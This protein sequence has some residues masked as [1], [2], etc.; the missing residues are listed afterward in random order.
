M[1][2][3]IFLL[4]V[5]LILLIKTLILLIKTASSQT[6]IRVDDYRSLKIHAHNEKEK[7]KNFILTKEVDSV[8]KYFDLNY[9]VPDQPLDKVIPFFNN[10]ERAFVNFFINDK[11]QLRSDIESNKHYFSPELNSNVDSNLSIADLTKNM[12]D[13]WITFSQE[14]IRIGVATNDQE[15]LL[16]LYLRRIINDLV[17]FPEYFVFSQDSINTA[18]RKIGLF[19]DPSDL[20]RDFISDHLIYETEYDGKGYSISFSPISYIS[21]NSGLKSVFSNSYGLSFDVDLRYRQVMF[22]LGLSYRYSDIKRDVVRNDL[23]WQSD[24]RAFITGLTGS[25]GYS[26]LNTKRFT[27]T[28]LAGYS[29]MR[30]TYSLADSTY[31]ENAEDFLGPHIALLAD[32]KLVKNQKSKA[33][34]SNITRLEPA[35]SSYFYIRLYAGH[36][37]SGFSNA[38]EER[39]SVTYVSLGVGYFV[40]MTRPRRGL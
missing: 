40:G 32:L 37:P 7:V 27:L 19:M 11:S 25:L 2:K 35:E 17:G 30:I 5:S 31:S 29:S 15:E 36:F 9:I 4:A 22:N 33:Y 39:G 34:S 13:F 6:Y 21:F 24:G 16:L 23:L 14:K 20:R 10:R 28:P 8:R 18:A 1:K 12:M 3:N 26:V 38:F